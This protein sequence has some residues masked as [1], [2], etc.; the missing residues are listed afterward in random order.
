MPPL[1]EFRQTGRQQLEA[2]GLPTALDVVMALPAWGSEVIYDGI[3]LQVTGNMGLW[4][5]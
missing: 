1:G 5:N 2:L 3:L 4:K